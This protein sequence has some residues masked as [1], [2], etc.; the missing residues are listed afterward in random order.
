[1]FGHNPA[2]KATDRISVIVVLLS[3]AVFCATAASAEFASA[4][5]ETANDIPA[6]GISAVVIPRDARPGDVVELRIEMSRESWGRFEFGKLGHSKLLTIA[7]EKVPVSY[8]NRRYKQRHSLFLQPV[9]SGVVE[10]SATSVNLSTADGEETVGLPALRLNVIPFDGPALSDSALPL[11][12]DEVA[13]QPPSLFSALFWIGVAFLVLGIWSL[14]FFGMRNQKT[15]S[16]R[17]DSTKEF[18]QVD[19]IIASL[20]SGVV[21]KDELEDLLQDS[22]LSFSTELRNKIEQAVYSVQ[23]EPAKLASCLQRELRP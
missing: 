23:V 21:P 19:I 9:S 20:T 1:M 13:A 6:H 3:A 15:Q 17:A 7:E 2:T 10:I 22:R 5:P 14:V 12:P 8:K 18:T 4:A 11:P 16:V